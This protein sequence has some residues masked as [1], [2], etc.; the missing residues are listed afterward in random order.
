TPTVRWLS[1]GAGEDVARVENGKTVELHFADALG[2]L[3]LA[4][5]TGGKTIASFVY[6]AFGEIV[7]QKGAA[8]HRKEFNGKENDVETGLRYYGARYYDPLLL[9]WTTADPRSS[10]AAA[11]GR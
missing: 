10:S 1:L 5:D 7:A 8:N 11:A 2:S 9:R 4:L 3:M 6:G